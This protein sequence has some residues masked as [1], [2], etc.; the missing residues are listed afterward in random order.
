MTYVIVGS[1]PIDGDYNKDIEEQYNSK[2][3]Q[4]I[5]C[6]SNH[7]SITRKKDQNLSNGLCKLCNINQQ[8]KVRQLALFVPLNEEF[9]DDEVEEYRQK[10]EKA[11]KLC[12]SCEKILEKKLGDQKHINNTF[13]LLLTLALIVHYD[14]KINFVNL[15]MPNF[16][17]LDSWHFISEV[18]LF[19]LDII[20]KYKA[21]IPLAGILT[22]L[23][24]NF[25]SHCLQNYI[26]NLFWGFLYLLFWSNYI[27][28]QILMCGVLTILNYQTG[29]SKK[30]YFEKSFP[31]K[32]DYKAD[33]DSKNSNLSFSQL[34]RTG[35]MKN[36]SQDLIAEASSDLC[37]N[38]KDDIKQAS[39]CIQ[40]SIIDSTMLPSKRNVKESEVF[41][42]S[43]LNI[44]FH[45]KCHS[46]ITSSINKNILKSKNLSSVGEKFCF[47]LDDVNNH[48]NE[49]NLGKNHRKQNRTSNFL[50]D[51]NNFSIKKISPKTVIKPAKFIRNLSNSW[52]NLD[53]NESSSRSSTPCTGYSYSKIDQYRFELNK[54]LNFSSSGSFVKQC[55]CDCCDNH[56]KLN[57]NY[58]SPTFLPLQNF[59]TPIRH[60]PFYSYGSFSNS[61]NS[62]SNENI[63]QSSCELL[64]KNNNKLLKYLPKM[65]FFF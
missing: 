30:I 48:L 5:L 2:L 3:N 10:L 19:Y 47:A 14:T 56:K 41:D 37:L 63:F 65:N 23:M 4:N 6:N 22:S 62:K 11:Y 64:N 25:E 33:N 54:P 35:K 31:R 61:S 58:Y 26:K 40:Q 46:N 15:Y 1:V 20:Y 44:Q 12:H 27:E 34:Q 16:E 8:L 39:K 9:Y 42:E 60:S 18:A 32:S 53:F 36:L 17:S 59:S 55:Y 43:Q 28:L 29:L 21:E 57:S 13:S 24:L 49:L 52:T 7:S 51:G 50:F 45:E 38:E